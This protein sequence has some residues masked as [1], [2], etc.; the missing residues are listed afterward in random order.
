MLVRYKKGRWPWNLPPSHP[1][2][3]IGANAHY[4][5]HSRGPSRVF[6]QSAAL[7]GCSLRGR[8]LN[9][10]HGPGR[11][12]SLLAA[13]KESGTTWLI[14][15]QLSIPSGARSLHTLLHGHDEPQDKIEQHTARRKQRQ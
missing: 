11:R 10:L 1:H 12:I 14:D 6:Q 9:R 15:W 7:F 8:F 3:S 13:G 2:S 4:G 5:N